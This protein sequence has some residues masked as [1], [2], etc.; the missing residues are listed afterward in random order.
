MPRQT[1]NINGFGG[2]N[3]SQDSYS[4]QD[5]Q[6]FDGSNLDLEVPG[7]IKGVPSNG[8]AL[9]VNYGE[10]IVSLGNVR[11]SGYIGY[12]SSG[13]KRDLIYWDG[14]NFKYIEQFD[15]TNNKNSY[16]LMNQ[17]N[18][19][20]SPGSDVAWESTECTILTRGGGAIL[21]TKDMTSSDPPIY[22]FRK[23]ENTQW[24]SSPSIGINIT[25]GF[26]AGLAACF[27]E[28]TKDLA[29]SFSPSR[30][31]ILGVEFDTGSSG[32]DW[33]ANTYYSFKVSVLYNTGEESN[34]SFENDII[35]TPASDCAK[36]EIQFAWPGYKAGTTAAD[37]DPR[38]TGYR[39]YVG[40][41]TAGNI[42][43]H[44]L[45]Y[46]GNVED[47]TPDTTAG[48][49]S[50]WRILSGSYLVLGDGTLVDSGGLVT[51]NTSGNTY[52]ELTGIPENIYNDLNYNLACMGGAYNFVT[53]AEPRLSRAGYETGGVYSNYLFRSKEYRYNMFNWLQDYLVLPFKARAL[54]YYNGKVWAMD[55]LHIARINPGGM[56]IEDV[57]DVPGAHNREAVLVTDIGLFFA[58]KIG[59]YMI[60]DA[61]RI[62]E[63][64]EEI[65]YNNAGATYYWTSLM[66]NFDTHKIKIGYDAIRKYVCF[67]GLIGAGGTKVLI[68]W[69]FHIP[70]KRWTLIIPTL[71][72]ATDDWGVF[73]T[74]D[75][76]IYISL[77]NS[78]TAGSTRALMGGG[79]TLACSGTTKCFLIDDV[80]DDKKFY[81][82]FY[83]ATSSGAGPT[84]KY[85]IDGSAASG[86]T[87]TSNYKIT[88]TR[89]GKYLN[90]NY[91]LS[92]GETIKELGF[93]YKL[94]RGER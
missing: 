9:L 84:V 11:D 53:N 54:A 56:Y 51:Y 41:G 59:A 33:L 63:L 75:G 61:N 28:G 79:S 4:I 88:G 32:T 48:G 68:T 14:V 36:V 15:G 52:E 34:L 2:I 44:R 21:A 1:L 82:I 85:A 7:I 60:D 17:G 45:L 64:S 80:R 30:L 77:D 27:N 86:T 83:E 93:I 65:K 23:L 81:V 20:L 55:E 57:F 6:V 73:P 8:T 12:E 89:K 87:I 5:N 39:V 42:G 38:I 37:I 62:I 18:M 91:A 25:A 47:L 78:G 40:E 26:R 50:S 10:A 94:L 22:A 31:Q 24:M 35:D 19:L 76:R 92:A 70:S 74:L 46:E 90:L 29:S 71:S 43:E 16:M 49:S 66:A 58:N 13:Y 67:F 72:T 3:T 69:A